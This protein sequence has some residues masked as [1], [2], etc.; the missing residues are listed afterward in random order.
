MLQVAL[1]AAAALD[2]L[3]LPGIERLSRRL[4]PIG[5]PEERADRQVG[6]A[7]LGAQGILLGYLLFSALG[8]LFTPNPS[9]SRLPEADRQVMR[10][11]E[12]NTPQGSRFAILHGQPTWETDKLSEWFP[13][14][15]GRI[16]L[17]TVQGNEWFP[18]GY[19]RAQAEYRALQTCFSRDASCLE[20]WEKDS[21]KTLDYLY[22]A[23]PER[24]SAL[25]GSV[26]K[27]AQYTLV[28]QNAAAAVFLKK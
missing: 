21:G 15:S 22:L 9:L 19:A 24:R 23:D 26:V 7:R 12:A 13:A 5:S 4:L 20:A 3:V 11:I 6:R 10:W 8:F 14:L 1:F 25:W 16:S 27:S 28:Y 18:G 17:A 2:D